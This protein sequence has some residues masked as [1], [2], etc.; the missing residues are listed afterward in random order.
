MSSVT[1]ACL[2]AGVLPLLAAAGLAAT[3]L[4]APSPPAGPRPG[5]RRLTDARGVAY[6]AEVAPGLYRG[7]QPS[8]EGVAWLK[9][10]GV[11][12]VL[13]LRHYHGDTEKGQ[14]ESVGLRYES[15]PLTSR[16]APRA[17]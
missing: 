8:A 16:D 2:L 10:I 12:T 7:G 17:E 4:A 1:R 14:V 5:A 9:S 13:N 6:A 15:I 3:G 11:K